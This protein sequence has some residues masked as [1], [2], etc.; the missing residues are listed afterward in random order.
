MCCSWVRPADGRG[1]GCREHAVGANI[2]PGIPR[3]VM[4]CNSLLDPRAR[5]ELTGGRPRLG[6]LVAVAGLG[7]RRGELVANAHS[8]RS[9]EN[10]TRWAG[11]VRTVTA[12]MEISPS[13]RSKES[14]SVRRDH[15]TAARLRCR[16]RRRLTGRHAHARGVR[17]GRS[18]RRTV[19]RGR[20]RPVVPARHGGAPTASTLR[21]PL[22]ERTPSG[23]D[24]NALR[25]GFAAAGGWAPVPV[26]VQPAAE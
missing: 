24:A 22:A 17:A 3:T 4:G 8:G 19:D 9:K 20:V 10:R 11:W 6:Q 15:L 25:A 26:A 16:R 21:G 13:P 14:L 7:D 12:V 2:E 1:R 5:R 18:A 23:S